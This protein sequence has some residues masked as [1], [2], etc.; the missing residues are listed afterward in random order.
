MKQNDTRER[1]KSQGCLYQIFIEIYFPLYYLLLCLLNFPYGAIF[2]PF[3]RKTS[4][5]DS[6]SC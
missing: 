4:Y 5:R 2:L 3:V 6:L 1:I